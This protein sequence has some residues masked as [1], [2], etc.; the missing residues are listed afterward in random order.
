M[1]KVKIEAGSALIS[2]LRKAGVAIPRYCYH[3]KLAI[4]GN[5]RMCL[6]DVERAPKPV[7]S[8]AFPVG[9]N[10]VVRTDTER[11]KRPVKVSWK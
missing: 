1:A 5:C 10:M 3:E 4:A 7:A 11:V 9:P 2:G 6:V 8:C